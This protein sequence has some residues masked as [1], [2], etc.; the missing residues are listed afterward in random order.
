M[1]NLLIKTIKRLLTCIICKLKKES[2]FFFV[3]FYIKNKLKFFF[4]SNKYENDKP[5]TIFGEILKHILKT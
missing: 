5:K 3:L 2:Y 1:Q 4:L